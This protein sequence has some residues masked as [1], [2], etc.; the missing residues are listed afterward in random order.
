M[1]I[2]YDVGDCVVCLFCGPQMSAHGMKKGAIHRVQ[3]I[4]EHHQKMGVVFSTIGSGKYPG[5]D[6]TKFKK[7]PQSI[8]RVHRANAQAEAAQEEG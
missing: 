4:F 7:T 5:W 3:M 2:D 6:A 1:Q 8:R